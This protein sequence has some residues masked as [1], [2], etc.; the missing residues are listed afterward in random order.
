MT[1]FL[2]YCSYNSIQGKL[3][4][5][6]LVL[7]LLFNVCGYHIFFNLAQS[8]LRREIKTRIR[9]GLNEDELTFIEVSARNDAE[10]MW[11]K[12]KKEFSY[13]G[14]RY[15]VVK[16][17]YKDGRTYIHC[18]NDIKENKLIT[19]YSKNSESNQKA[20]KLLNNIFTCFVANIDLFFHIRE[21]SDHD[22]YS[23]QSDLNLIIKEIADP[24]PKS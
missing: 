21:T 5:F 20:R 2:R 19:E 10:I 1:S 13:H 15:D 11:I 23:Y 12:P 22:Y 3:T 8:N 14:N 6:C 18:I 17:N 16:I 4:C 7:I 24:P 9:E